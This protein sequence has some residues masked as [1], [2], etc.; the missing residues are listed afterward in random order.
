[1]KKEYMYL[2]AGVLVGVYV[3]P[4]LPIKLPGA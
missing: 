1:M 2:L 4:K 3:M